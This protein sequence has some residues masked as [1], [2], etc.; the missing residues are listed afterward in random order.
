MAASAHSGER[1]SIGDGE[2]NLTT[3]PMAYFADVTGAMAF[4]SVRKQAFVPS[5][6]RLSL[7]TEPKAVWSRI[8]IVNSGDY[9]RHLFLH[10]PYVYHSKLA[11]FYLE[12][13]GEL[14]DRQVLDLDDA[15]DSPLMYRG[16]AVYEFELPVGATRTLYVQTVS[17]SHQWF[18]LLLVDQEHSRRMLIG[19]HNDIAVL[20]GV[21][22]AL[23][24]Y[25]F[26]LYFASSN[27]E[28]IFYS[29][30]LVSGAVWISLSYGLLA[31]VFNVYGAGIFKLH[32]SLISMPIFLTLFM[33]SILGTKDDYPREHLI[34]KVMLCT[35]TLQFTWGLFDIHGA[36]KPASTM[37]ALMMLVTMGVTISLVRKGNLLAKFFLIGHSFFL[38]FNGVA[39]LFYKGIIGFTYVASHGV[40]IGITL[41]ALMLA[42][43]IAY[44]IRIL[45]GIKDSQVELKRQAVTDPLTM[46]FNRR[47]FFTEA[48]DIVALAKKHG[49]AVSV[50]AVDV[51]HFKSV[52]DQY[53]HQIGDELLVNLADTLKFHCRST[54]LIARFGGEEF[55]C[56]L[57]GCDLPE[58]T[59]VAEKLRQAVEEQTVVLDGSEPLRFTIS[60][61]VASVDMAS[62]DIQE[63]LNEAD[64]A[65]Y[66][67]K[68]AGRNRVRA[69]ES[70]EVS[71]KT[72]QPVS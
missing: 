63:A 19:T 71:G 53:G 18:T 61:G 39:V 20:I 67:A 70:P 28:N 40:G 34:L 14:V 45:E 43:I 21:L 59:G 52:N 55:V 65:L 6:N 51:D 38:L 1:V 66:Q 36:L 41:E 47:Y 22:V 48:K 49:R 7:G 57:P 42:F 32:L 16:S 62:G 46:L 5:P 17:Y 11:G 31:N 64:R 23:I 15:S 58:A 60:V 69:I 13:S 2:V 3:F 33:M 25:N 68:N 29:L 12:D 56:L 37:A 4:D 27:K 26:L 44:R 9:P 10:H 35:L 72:L 30:Y 54:D 50:F 24:F 8:E